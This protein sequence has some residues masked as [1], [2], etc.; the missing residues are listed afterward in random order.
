L[1]VGCW[2][3]TLACNSLICSL[4]AAFSIRKASPSFMFQSGITNMV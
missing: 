2:A 4:S 3:F 1:I